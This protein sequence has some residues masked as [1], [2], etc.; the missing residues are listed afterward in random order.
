MVSMLFPR[1]IFVALSLSLVALS[2]A[3]FCGWSSPTLITQS[4]SL[5]ATRQ[6]GDLAADPQGGVVGVFVGYN[7]S[8]QALQAYKLPTN[9][10][11]WIPFKMPLS[12]PNESAYAP[13]IAINTHGTMLAVWQQNFTQAL[14]L[15]IAPI[16]H[17]KIQASSSNRNSSEWQLYPTFLPPYSANPNGDVDD[18][19]PKLALNEAGS[20]VALWL[21]NAVIQAAVFDKG[22]WKATNTLTNPA[23]FPNVVIDAEGNAIA[24]W[25]E[26]LFSSNTNNRIYAS[27]LPK[28][29]LL[30]E[31]AQLLSSTDP[32]SNTKGANLAIDA[33]GNV[34]A[35]WTSFIHNDNI[36]ATTGHKIQ[37][38]TLAKG[39]NQWIPFPQDI[40]SNTTPPI[41]G[42]TIPNI[43]MTPDGDAV[44]VWAKQTTKERTTS[45]VQAA[46]LAKGSRKWE[47]SSN[48]LFSQPDEYAS[49]PQVSINPQ[50]NAVAAWSAKKTSG[51]QVI[52]A[53]TLSKGSQKWVAAPKVPIIAPHAIGPIVCIDVK[54]HVALAWREKVIQN[55][56]TTTDTI[57]A[58]KGIGFF[59]K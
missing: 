48:L 33:T 40:L 58:T 17:S 42:L 11:T 7:G 8:Y 9:S 20:A 5:A 3:A 30:W 57:Y 1:K 56:K 47:L 35:V 32:S 45:I 10:N 43:A 21:D 16:R 49:T 54:N 31:P 28:G 2:Q 14:F 29:S 25:N 24:V 37:G 52:M 22:V 13:Q 19:Q 59:D 18:V 41:F 23:T 36:F 44:L 34:I 15:P 51:E 53:A 26:L 27:K 50:G 39:S 55:H 38:A 12:I 4:G 46:T 6:L